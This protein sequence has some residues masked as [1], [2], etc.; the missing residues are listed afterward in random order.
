MKILKYPHPVLR[1]KAAPVPMITRELGLQAAEMLELMYEHEG[2]GL[3]GPQVGLPIQMI[4]LNLLADKDAKEMEV[5]AIN[6]TI[7]ETRGAQI[8]DREGCLSFPGLFSNVRRFKTVKVQAYNLQGERFEMVVS[9]L[10]A[11]LWQHE[12]DHLQGQL[13]IDKLGPIGKM[14]TRKQV[15]E[16]IAE[17]EADWKKAGSPGEE[18]PLL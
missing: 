9:D 12:M 2:L 3:A 15:E 5:V 1:A 11:R 8:N 17:Y 7:L 13:F 18:T 4:V 6:P 14:N 16:F 10:Y